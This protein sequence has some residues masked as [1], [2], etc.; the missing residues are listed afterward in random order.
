MTEPEVGKEVEPREPMRVRQVT[1]DD[2]RALR[3]YA[4][5]DDAKREKETT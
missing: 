2:G 4:F 1:K 3:F 5:G